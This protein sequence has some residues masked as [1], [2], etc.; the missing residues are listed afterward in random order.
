MT[1]ELLLGAFAH[2]LKKHCTPAAVR[3]ADGGAGAEAL[4][5]EIVSAGFADALVS[6]LT[7]RDVFPLIV[8]CGAFALPLPLAETMLVR[9]HL[10]HLGQPLPPGPVSLSD[11]GLA[12]E[13]A[14]AAITSA[15]MA[16]AMQTCLG[17]ALAHARERHQF[18]RSIGK[19]QAVQ[20]QLAI[21]AE[22]AAAV[23]IAAQAA[24]PLV[25]N[26]PDPLRAAVAKARAS[27]AVPIVV[28]IAHAVH[29]AIG[30]T[31]ECDLQLYTKRL[32]RWRLANGGEIYWHEKIG[33]ALL[34]S[35]MDV[36]SFTRIN[37]GS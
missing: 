29:G 28:G 16:G 17:L 8:A 4:W 36:L 31:A 20:H 34:Q 5:H 14:S 32:N 3:A 9:A 23:R 15:L 24:F 13:T 18:G 26:V 6:G 2:L 19:F 12:D 1:D 33:A 35:E 10:D 21:M 30:M 27:E 25:G 37:L 22:H 11:A 7:L